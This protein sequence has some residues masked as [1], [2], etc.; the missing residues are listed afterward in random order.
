MSPE[1]H[2]ATIRRMAEAFNKR[3]LSFIDHDFLPHFF[4]HTARTPGWPR[5]LESARQL[6]TVM[7]TTAPDM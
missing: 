3:E 4:L 5:G 6:F 2:K 7:L 1:D